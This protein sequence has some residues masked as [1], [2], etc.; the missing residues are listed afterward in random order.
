MHP[1]ISMHL[2]VRIVTTNSL[3]NTV[4]ILQCHARDTSLT[5]NG[6]VRFVDTRKKYSESS[7]RNER[8]SSR[9]AMSMLSCRYESAVVETPYEQK[10]TVRRNLPWSLKTYVAGVRYCVREDASHH[11]ACN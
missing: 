9:V 6:A 10:T 4:N 3:S 1:L 11:T 2:L 5:S 7:L 8:L